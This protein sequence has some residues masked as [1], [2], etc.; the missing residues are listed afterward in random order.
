MNA[1][2]LPKDLE[3]WAE[4]EVAA[5]RAPSVEALAIGALEAYRRQW[6]ELRQSIDD[7]KAEADRDGWLTIEEAFEGMLDD[8]ANAE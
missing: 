5:G 3:V 2:V 1:I 4:A 7:A 6:E 8:G